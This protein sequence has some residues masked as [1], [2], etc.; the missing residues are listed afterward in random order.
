MPHYGLNIST[1]QWSTTS[2]PIQRPA[3]GLYQNK[4]L[5]QNMISHCHGINDGS[6]NYSE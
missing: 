6:L 5:H 4:A 1:T 3:E 2:K